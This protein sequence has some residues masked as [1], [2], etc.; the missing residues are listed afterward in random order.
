M[1]GATNTDETVAL[2]IALAPCWDA[3]AP[4]V[5]DTPLRA[6]ARDPWAARQAFSA[7]RPSS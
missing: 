5:Q 3:L 2:I 1:A 4:D 7:L 6:A